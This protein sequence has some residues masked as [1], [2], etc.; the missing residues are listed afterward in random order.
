MRLLKRFYHAFSGLYFLIRREQSFRLHLVLFGMLVACSFYFELNKYEWIAVLIC[1]SMVFALE[2]VNSSIEQ[3]ANR[4][5]PEK[6]E[7]IK[8]VKDMAAAAVLIAALFSV[9]VA[10]VIFLPKLGIFS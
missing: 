9:G 10:L 6:H 2:A 1:S 4:L 5:H 8:W 7:Q 3:L